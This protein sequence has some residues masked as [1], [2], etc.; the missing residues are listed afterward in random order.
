MPSR[1]GLAPSRI[2]SLRLEGMERSPAPRRERAW[3]PF[4]ALQARRSGAWRSER[5]QTSAGARGRAVAQRPEHIV[6]NDQSHDRGHNCLR[7]QVAETMTTDGGSMRVGWLS[8]RAREGHHRCRYRVGAGGSRQRWQIMKQ[9]NHERQ[10]Q[11][12]C[13][14]PAPKESARR[15]AHDRLHA[16]VVSVHRKPFHPPEYRAFGTFSRRRRGL[17]RAA[18]LHASPAGYSAAMA[19]R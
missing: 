4:N 11:P 5:R 2:A 6:K 10:R 14:R 9:R 18:F 7:A 16:A 17:L 19:R 13:Q 3:S 8:R 1:D 12:E 15:C